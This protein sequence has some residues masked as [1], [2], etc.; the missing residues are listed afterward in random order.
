MGSREHDPKLVKLTQEFETI[1]VEILLSQ[2]RST[3][4]ALAQSEGSLARQTYEG[5]QDQEIS[6]S[7]SKGGSIGLAAMLYQQLQQK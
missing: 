3:S 5:W 2:M 4:R 1:F 6:K 7:L